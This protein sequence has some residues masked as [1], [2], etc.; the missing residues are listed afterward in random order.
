[1][2]RI[3]R[4]TAFWIR[5]SGVRLSGHSTI[6][7]RHEQR[8]G[9]ARLLEACIQSLVRR[10]PGGAAVRLGDRAIGTARK[11]RTP[12]AAWRRTRLEHSVRLHRPGALHREVARR[13]LLAW[14]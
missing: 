5:W 2:T 13:A 10:R 3:H 8:I 9:A 11:E 14:A 1:M 6:G 7:A 4:A 12:R